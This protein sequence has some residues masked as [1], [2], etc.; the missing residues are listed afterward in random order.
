MIVGG[1]GGL[2][3]GSAVPLTRVVS[4]AAAAPVA[5]NT[6]PKE[7]SRTMLDTPL[8]NWWSALVIARV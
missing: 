4:A 5:R 3:L 8:S 2:E 1:R 7:R 6:I